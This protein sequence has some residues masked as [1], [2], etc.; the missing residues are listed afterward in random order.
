MKYAIWFVRLVFVAWMLPAGVNHFIPLFAQPLGNMPLSRELFAA[1]DA[2]HLFDLVKA[3]ELIAALCVLTGLY[4]P[5][6]LLLCMPI[7]FCVWYWDAPLQ[8]WGSISALYGWGVLLTN[9]L[10]CLAY[11]RNYRTMLAPLARAGAAALPAVQRIV[12][13]SP[14]SLL[15]AR[16]VFGIWMLLSGFNHFFLA[17][18]AE[19][20]GTQPLAEQLM[21]ALIHSRLLDVVMAIQLVTGALILAGLFVP[22]ALCVAM[23]ISVC[24]AYWAVILEHQPLGALLGLTALALNGLLMLAHLDHYGGVLERR[25]TAFGE[26]D[27][28]QGAHYEALFVQAGGRTAQGPFAAALV[29]LAAAALFYHVLIWGKPGEWAMLVLLFPAIVIHARRLHDMGWRAWPLLVPAVPVAGAIWYHMFAP[30]AAAERPA[31][32]AALAVSA[33]FTLWCLIGKSKAAA[34]PHGEL[35]WAS[36]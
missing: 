5:L 6:G 4:V 28:L 18:Y 21:D 35:G 31:V 9:A 23:P 25:A 11:V 27:G 3:V 26:Q 16:L 19:P 15:A 30:G 7:S 32:W 1:L 20:A 34:N 22:L 12:A 8:G 10:L 33:A 29:P 2:S 17:L 36:S 24:A 14:S 13:E